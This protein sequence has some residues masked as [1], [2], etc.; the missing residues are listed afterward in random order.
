MKMFIH[1]HDPEY[2]SEEVFLW[3]YQAYFKKY[4][5]TLSEGGGTVAHN[6]I[7]ITIHTSSMQATRPNNAFTNNTA[8][9]VIKIAV[10]AM[11]LG[12]IISFLVLYPYSYKYVSNSCADIKRMHKKLIQIKYLLLTVSFILFVAGLGILGFVLL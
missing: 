5:E 4:K 7:I 12:L 2:S 9:P 6:M 8:L 1:E 10:I 3:F 11:I